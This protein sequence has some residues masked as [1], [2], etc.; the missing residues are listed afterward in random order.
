MNEDYGLDV[1]YSLPSEKDPFPRS[2][3]VAQKVEGGIIGMYSGMSLQKM[4]EQYGQIAVTSAKEF[5][6]MEDEAHTTAPVEIE[7]QAYWDALECLPPVLWGN[8]R[9]M[10]SFR[11]S[12]RYC[13]NITTI[14]AI[15]PDRRY[16]RFQDRIDLPIE[17]LYEKVMRAV[18]AKPDK[19]METVDAP[20]CSDC[21]A[22]VSD[23]I[24][25]PDGSEICSACFDAGS[26]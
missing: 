13:G 17:A 4:A 10:E 20:S 24:G 9:G 1:I 2:I 5:S 11:F 14:F 21:G 18:E 16:W 23:V 15:S 26:H 22:E 25:C 12:E 3:D 19:A 7:Q 8:Y 6:R